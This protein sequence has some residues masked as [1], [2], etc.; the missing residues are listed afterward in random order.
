MSNYIPKNPLICFIR[1][2]PEL[3]CK[4]FLEDNK[5]I[6]EHQYILT[7]D[8]YGNWAYDFYI[9]K[10]NLL[11]EVDG[12]YYHRIKE[13]FNRDKIKNKLAEK[14]GFKIIRISDLAI[15][16]CPKLD[17]SLILSSDESIIENNIRV[18]EEREK[19]IKEK[20]KK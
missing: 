17:F 16:N 10:L 2:N 3:R 20:N 18:M 11:V 9:E 12:E 7:D 5:I 1:E 13:S 15:G 8:I 4:K 6:Y 19:N 14:H